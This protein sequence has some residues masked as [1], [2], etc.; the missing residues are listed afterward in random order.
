MFRVMLYNQ[1]KWSRLIVLLGSVA[2]FAL[3]IVSV[4]GAARADASPLVPAELLRTVQ[5]WGVLYPVLAATLGLLVA[6]ATWTPDHRGRHVHALLLPVP[7]WRYVLL[8]FGAGA[9][10]LAAPILAVTAGALLATWSATIPA[11]L[12][13]YPATL[14]VRFALAVLVAFS[15]FF[16]VAAGTA[17]TAG[18]I[19][20]LIGAVIVVQII[21]HVASVDLD[22]LGK[23]QIVILNWPGPLA[24]FAGRW[25]LIDV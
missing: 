16:A 21:A 3:P 20:A 4:Q 9:T 7:R 18:I 22:L 11:G 24:I 5:S 17:R 13:G 6:I 25:M 2:G 12:Q 10:L 8:R 1:W 14:A 23:L 19:L 15:V